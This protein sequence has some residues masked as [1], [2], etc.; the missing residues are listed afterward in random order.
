MVSE[1]AKEIGGF[2]DHE[3]VRE[4]DQVHDVDAQPE[5][6]REEAAQAE[7]R[8]H[9]ADHD[10]DD[11]KIGL[12]TRLFWT[13]FGRLPFILS[14]SRDP[15]TEETAVKSARG[16]SVHLFLVRIWWE[17]DSTGS[18]QRRGSVEHVPSGTHMHF[19]SLQDMSDFIHMRSEEQEMEPTQE[20]EH[21]AQAGEP[22]G[23]GGR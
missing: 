4:P 21:P 5:H 1:A 9:L 18:R 2:Q 12:S 20:R 13:L 17:H 14:S 8:D 3:P 22:T 16:R 10:R 11:L 23:D 19:T 6:P 15:W 7:R